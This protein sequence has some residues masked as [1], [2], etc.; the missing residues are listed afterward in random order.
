MRL[1]VLQHS[2]LDHPGV[3]R[4]YMAEDGIEWD[5]IDT[6]TGCII[7]PLDS[8]DALL[9]MGGPQQTDQES[10]YPW[11]KVE[12]NYIRRAI[13]VEEKPVL[14][15][16][17]G[18]QLIADVMGGRVGR[19]AMPEIGILDDETVPA[20]WS[21]GARQN[22]AMAFERSTGVAAGCGASYAFTRL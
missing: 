11:L 13:L 15:I 18:S 5:P 3:M 16:C 9:V 2:P 12:K 14:G 19:M 6:Y 17:L 10:A 8:Y 22:P 7:P 21:C 4:R 1:L 20:R